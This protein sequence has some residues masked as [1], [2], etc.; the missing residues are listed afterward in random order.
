M[1]IADCRF[2]GRERLARFGS[3]RSRREE[4]RRERLPS[5]VILYNEPAAAGAAGGYIESEAGVLEEVNAVAAALDRLGATCRKASAATLRDVPAALAAGDEPVVFNLVEGFQQRPQ[6]ANLAP[7]VCIAMGRSF[8]GN[9]TECLALSLDKWRSKAVLS[10]AGVPVPRAV[11]V[12]PGQRV[13]RADLPPGPL[14]VKPVFTDA[15]EGIH[16]E[17]SIVPGAGPRL[18]RALREIHE[19]F[20]QPAIV[21]QYI[22]GRELNVSVVERAGQAEVLA[23]AEIDFSTFQPGMHRIVD[24]AAKWLPNTFGYNNT[25]RIL[26]APLP[27]RVERL[28]RQISLRAWQALGCRDYARVDFRLDEAGRPMVLEVNPNPDISP[29]GGFASAVDFAGWACED[30]VRNCV[31]NAMRA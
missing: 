26:P 6:E 17:R 8:T 12:D 31:E 22:D 29:E 15:S 14:I 27:R 28:T 20:A 4:S 19:K 24:Y 21:E 25:P 9:T 16:A 18:A 1:P 3:D 2:S 13:S 5:V 7:A 10:A 23:V 11:L 30:F